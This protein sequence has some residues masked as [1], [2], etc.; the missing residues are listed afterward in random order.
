MDHVRL[1]IGKLAKMHAASVVY[2]EQGGRF[3]AKYDEGF[4]TPKMIPIFEHSYQ[5]NIDIMREA[6]ANWACAK[7]LNHFYD[8]WR[9]IFLKKIF[10]IA[11]RD[12]SRFSVLC[13]GD[14]WV[15]NIM[16]KYSAEGKV[17]DCL[18]VDYQICN[19]NSPALDLH[20]FIFSSLHKDLRLT[21]ID[22]IIALYHKELLAN[23]KRLGYKKTPTTLLQLQKDF[24]ATGLFGLGTALGT[25][26]IAVAPSTEDSDINSF[27]SD[28]DKAKK[29]KL[30]LY[31]NPTYRDGMEAMVPYF[32]RKGYFEL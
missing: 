2:L 23:L 11:Q 19:Y 28:S 25:F 29:F 15:N 7:T 27:V 24:L 6:S 3:D 16:F 1:T 22:N 9:E 4:Y 13:H 8:N 26:P 18:L 30:H 12:D 10:P 17:Q 31:G 32:E 20:Y 14:L 21:Q 5:S